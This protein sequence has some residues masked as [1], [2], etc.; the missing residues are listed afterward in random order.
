MVYEL[1]YLLVVTRVSNTTVI[2]TFPL[3]RLVQFCARSFAYRL[4]MLRLRLK[5]KQVGLFCEQTG[6]RREGGGVR[7]GKRIEG[8]G[9]CKASVYVCIL[10][11]VPF[12]TLNCWCILF[13][14][15]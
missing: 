2:F 14:A 4:E 13:S 12:G 3:F 1:Q 5:R 10:V 11:R 8:E 9:G 6:G 15:Y 7:R